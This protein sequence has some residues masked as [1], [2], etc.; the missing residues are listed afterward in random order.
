MASVRNNDATSP[1]HTTIQSCSPGGA[2]V[3][4]S[5]MPQGICTVPVLAVCWV[6]LSILTNVSMLVLGRSP[7]AIKIARGHA[8][9][10][11]PSNTWF[12]API[13]IHIP[14]GILIG[15]AIFA[16][17][18]IVTDWPTDRQ[19]D[20][21]TPSVAIGRIAVL[22]RCGLIILNTANTEQ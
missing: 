9:I 17:L 16:E 10:W 3:H 12:L 15:S 13:Q 18:T 21:A 20:H 14:N 19:T 4:P 22:C 1:P 5:S 2:S 11:T 6:A 7:S 8:R